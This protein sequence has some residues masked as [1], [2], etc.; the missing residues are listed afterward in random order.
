MSES[1]NSRGHR[2]GPRTTRRDAQGRERNRKT[3]GK[4][5]FSASAPS[6]RR[7]VADPDRLVAYEVLRAVD[8]QD[9]YAN[10]VL[11]QAIR[12]HRL[13]RR[14]AGFATELAY[15]TLRERG[16]YDEIL[17]RCLD[18]SLEKTDPKILSALRL[19]AHQLLGMRVPNHAALNQTVGLARGVIGAGPSTLV[20]AVLRR[21]SEKSREEWIA[22]LT[23]EVTDDIK[24][25]SIEES[26][27]VW[28]VRAFRQS[29]A[30][31]GRV[32]TEIQKLL[33]ADNDSPSVHLVA[34]PGIGDLDEAFGQ[35]AVPGELVEGS[36]LFSH[37]DLGR[38]ESVRS[39]TVRAQDAGS[40]IVARALAAAPLEGADAA[41]LDLCAG[42]GGKAALLGALAASKGAELVA[43]ESS[44]HRAD[45]VRQALKPLPRDMYSV[46]TGDG[47][48]VRE[49]L[50][51]ADLPEN[52]SLAVEAFGDDGAVFDRVMV[53]APCSGLGALR[54]RPEARWRKKPSDLAELTSLQ[55]ELARAAVSVT[56][57][58]GVVAYVTCSPHPA[59]TQN[60]LLDLL[61]DGEVE[62]L[63]T[64]AAVR[65]V[66]KP[67]VFDGDRDPGTGVPGV[68]PAEGQDEATTI[69]LWPHV[70]GTD[71]MFL[72]LLRKK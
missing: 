51:S 19:G 39:G 4:R 2:A 67:G 16:T 56:R 21:V 57:P 3:Q 43:N 53:D 6:G 65:S 50:L 33:A 27:P 44:E 42:P 25:M 22:E 30:A 64:A 58:G 29:L 1:N 14:D 60:V 46:L 63:D 18:R 8:E 10:L 24:R 34:L 9:S 38:L 35:E 72:A 31:H 17:S 40:Q 5:D 12:K 59:E 32:P 61:D 70:H 7:R 41:W 36:A 54:R 66:A 15:G 20:N 69:Q 26:H 23:A 13:D 48:A 71:A 55:L 47:R 28:I 49:N 62:L 11:P 37:G 52:V 45:L 68:L